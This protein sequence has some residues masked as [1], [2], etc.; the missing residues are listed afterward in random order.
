MDVSDYVL[1]SATENRILV[2]HHDVV[3]GW[4]EVSWRWERDGTWLYLHRGHLEPEHRAGVSALG[5][6]PGPRDASV[7][8]LPDKEPGRRPCSARARRRGLG[9]AVLLDGLR[10]LRE[11]GAAR[12]RLNTGS[13]NPHRSYALYNSVGFHQYDES[14]RYRKPA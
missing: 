7:N 14:V 10:R 12:V 5:C 13:A 11:H 1:R 2:M 9:R 8:S 6:W 3:V 4:V